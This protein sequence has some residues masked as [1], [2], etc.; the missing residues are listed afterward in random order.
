MYI[1]YRVPRG[2][3]N[4]LRWTHLPLY[5][6]PVLAATSPVHWELGVGIAINQEIGHQ[7]PPGHRPATARLEARG[8]V[9]KQIKKATCIC[10]GP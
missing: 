5:S 6:E 1:L 3:Q 8:A 10:R 2:C 4:K 7:Q 9:K